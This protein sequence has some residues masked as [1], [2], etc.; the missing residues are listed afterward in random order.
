MVDEKLKKNI[1]KVLIVFTMVFTLLIGYLSYFE[2][3]YG[4]TIQSSTYNKRNRDKENEILRGSIFDRNKVLIAGS[5]RLEDKTQKRVY[6][7]GYEMPYAPIIGY[8]SSKYGS[9]A[10]EQV[11][12]TELLNAEMLN[13]F[14]VIRDIITSAEMKGENIVL[15][16]DSNLQKAAYDALGNNK[17]AVAA[18]DPKTGEI[19]CMVSKPVF[20]PLTIDKDWNT[21]TK[22]DEQGYFINRAIQP[23]IYPPGSTFKVVV[24]SSAIENIKDIESRTF[25]CNGNIK[26]NNYTLKDFGSE[27]H[28]KI[29]L[30]DALADSCNVTFGQIG[31][32]LGADRLKQEAEDF[33]FNNDIPFDLQVA[34]SHF[35]TID[36]NRKDS[37]AQSAIGQ[38]EVTVTPLQMLL[39][40]S[41]IANKGVMMKPFLVKAV[42]D[43]YGWSVKIVK[44]QV[45]AQPVKQETAQKIKSMMV[46]V[47][48]EG[49]GRNAKIN[50][51]DVAGKTGT[52]EVG[53]GI[54]PHSWFIAFAPAD[55]PK[56]AIAVIA[57][58]GEIGGGKAAAIAKE[59]ISSYFKK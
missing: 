32:E 35:P 6:K 47:V 26:I 52:A 13:P 42:T 24:A 48:K 2:I 36:K 25:V 4:D 55:D 58:N 27:R 53:E 20:N 51:I 45:L 22:Q 34:Q 8:Y 5:Q 16:T 31:M 11:Y 23:G 17:G 56:I 30:H 57:E 1:I 10:L 33:Y 40:A 14:K 29:N 54:A 44:P 43:S 59:V 3:Y 15:T 19:L 37:L 41:A 50:G 9:S 49:T 12:S 28:G 46:D 18:M 21:I 7:K 38:F 39:V